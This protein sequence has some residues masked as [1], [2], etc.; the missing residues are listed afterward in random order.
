MQVRVLSRSYLLSKQVVNG[1]F[2]ALL[3]LLMIGPVYLIVVHSYGKFSFYIFFQFPIGRITVRPLLDKL[4]RHVIVY[5]CDNNQGTPWRNG[6]ASDSRSEGCV[7]ESRR[8]H[9]IFA[10]LLSKICKRKISCLQ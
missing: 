2:P 6:S 5:T 4:D 9:K 7:F 8:G 10:T 3:P 1:K